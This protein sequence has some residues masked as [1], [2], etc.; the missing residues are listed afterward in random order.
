MQETL[1]PVERFWSYVSDWILKETSPGCS[2]VQAI[3]SGF[4]VADRSLILNVGSLR[5]S[6]FLPV[7]I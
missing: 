2:K 4:S 3:S 5:N 6:A 7:P 1:K